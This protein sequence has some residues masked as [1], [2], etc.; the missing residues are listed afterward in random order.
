MKNLMSSIVGFFVSMLA[1]AHQRL[2]NYMAG[3]GLIACVVSLP[4]GTIFDIA[5]GYDA[6]KNMT[7]ISN[8]NPAVATLAASHGVTVGSFLELTSG[9]AR[10]TNKVVK[11]GTIATNDVQLLGIDS[12]LTTIYPAAGG[13]GTVRRITGW[14]Q[15]AQVLDSQSEGGEQRFTTYQFLESDQEKRIP[16]TKSAGGLKLMIADDPTLPGYLLA[17]AAND[18]RLPRA[19]RATL[20]SGSQILYNCYISLNKTPS[21]TINE[22]M[23]CE[24]TLSLL[25]EVVRY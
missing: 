13:A 22:V 11:A 21:M 4:N 25:A 3:Q 8:A 15:L 2:F 7:A 1:T 23:A 12:S 18:D 5:S 19:V 20:P 10:L 16:T 14:T 6:A 9:W 24:A 17:A